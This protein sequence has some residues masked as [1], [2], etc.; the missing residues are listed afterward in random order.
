MPIRLEE[1]LPE[2]REVS[3]R[4]QPEFSRKTDWTLGVIESRLDVASARQ[5]LWR[6]ARYVQPSQPVALAQ[7]LI[8]LAEVELQEHQKSEVRRLL[9]PIG[10][11]L[12]V[13][14]T[15]VPEIPWSQRDQWT[16]EDLEM[17][18]QVIRR[19][20]PRREIWRGR[21]LELPR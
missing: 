2:I 14:D 11:L 8:D 12:D 10:H 20:V 16:S 6:Y 1:S 15:E 4:V 21:V 3:T 9:A 5:R 17:A 7:V 19:S 13:A 18:R